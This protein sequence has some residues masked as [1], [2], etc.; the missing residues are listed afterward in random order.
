MSL[1]ID[2]LQLEM[3]FLIRRC[4]RLNPFLCGLLPFHL[5]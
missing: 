5:S 2:I 4:H 1:S 3:R